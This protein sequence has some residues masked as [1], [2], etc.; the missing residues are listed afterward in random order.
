[1]DNS[2]ANSSETG[3]PILEYHLVGNNGFNNKSLRTI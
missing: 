2:F 1:M 3:S